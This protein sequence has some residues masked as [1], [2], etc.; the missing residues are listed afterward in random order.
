MNGDLSH[1]GFHIYRV[2][3]FQLHTKDRMLRQGDDVV[4]L[5][6]KMYDVLL[7]LVQNPGRVLTK[8]ELLEA[9][10]SDTIVEEGNLA[11]TI[12]HLRK[13]LGDDAHTPSYIQTVARRGYRFIAAVEEINVNRR[14]SNSLTP[15]S[16]ASV[17]SFES[18]S[19]S[20]IK[21]PIFVLLI[22]IVVLFTASS[23]ALYFWRSPGRAMADRLH[24]LRVEKLSDTGN[25]SG[26][27]I[28]PDGRLLAYTSIEAGKSIIWLRQ[29]TTGKSVQ[30]TSS[31][32]TF[33]GLSFSHDAEF[34]YYSHSKGGGFHDVSRISILGG[35]PI[36]ILSDVHAASSFSPDGTRVAFIRFNNGSSSIAVANSDGGDEKVVLAAPKGRSIVSVEWTP[37]GGALGYTIGKFPSR[38]R[39]FA[40]MRLDLS[41]G[42]DQP[43][44]DFRWN[45]LGGLI[46][47]P[48][49]TGVLASGRDSAD[50]KDQIWL[51]KLSDGEARQISSDSTSLALRG[52]TSDLSKIVATQKSKETQIWVGDASNPTS[53]Q[54]FFRAESDVAWSNDGSVVFTAMDTPTSDIWIANSDGTNRRQLTDSREVERSPVV[55]PDGKYV[56]YVSGGEKQNIW[57]IGIDGRGPIQL[58]NGEGEG[59][60]TFTPD[61]RYVV[62]NSLSDGKLMKVSVDGGEPSLVFD[63][64]A[65]RVAI[66]P[67]GERFAYIGL[68]DAARTLFIRRLGDGA[69]LKEIT[70]G[71]RQVSPS[72]I[73]WTSDGR[74]ILYFASDQNR[75]DNLFRQ[76]LEPSTSEQLTNFTSE[77]IFDFGLSNDGRRIAFVRGKWTHD[78]VLLTSSD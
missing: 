46:W 65:M 13:T 1:N 26:A 11:V 21:R 59:Y 35:T 20:R 4:A 71:G 5:T 6:P 10:W 77:E 76:R 49:N 56:A 30:V 40:V 7:V 33:V 60:P 54:P 34:L 75:I 66:S 51:V 53:I 38:D 47:L 48:D 43:I 9:A 22:A 36:K 29:L 72:R 41:T 16:S 3:E 18:G 25:G 73:V 57:R 45:F 55:S 8:E 15:E 32:E 39:D 68:K 69:V 27:A 78:A 23:G 63:E 42:A 24:D 50:G 64:R 74:S 17:D 67:D 44:S 31:D 52:T 19:G 2:G 37:D 28:S 70:I 14:E 62:Y 12:A 58:T 61:G